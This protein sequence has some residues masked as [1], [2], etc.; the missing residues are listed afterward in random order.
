M[1]VWDKVQKLIIIIYMLQKLTM[2]VSGQEFATGNILK[3]IKFDAIFLYFLSVLIWC[4]R[5]K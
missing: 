5:S 2:T 3:N 4:V 1:N